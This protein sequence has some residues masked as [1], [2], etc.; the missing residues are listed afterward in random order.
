MP[1]AVH[2]MAGIGCTHFSMSSFIRGGTPSMGGLYP[3]RTFSKN[4][5]GYMVIKMR[6][7]IPCSMYDKYGTTSGHYFTN[8]K[9]NTC[10]PIVAAKF[11]VRC[12]FSCYE[13]PR[14]DAVGIDVGRHTIALEV[15][16]EHFRG[17]VKRRA[18]HLGV[19]P[20]VGGF[21]MAPGKPEVDDLFRKKKK[22]VKKRWD[23]SRGRTKDQGPR[24][25]GLGPRTKDQGPRPRTK[26]LA[27]TKDLGPSTKDLGPRI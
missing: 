22:S 3:P 16:V 4:V 5:T 10:E 18:Y 25:K 21:V 8:P 19:V 12:G 20:R 23:R 11:L 1:A 2:L 26:D 15:G 24:T 17:H 13:L 27:R 6:C 7:I 14:D 9:N